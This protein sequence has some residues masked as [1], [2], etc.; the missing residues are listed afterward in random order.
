MPLVVV[1][2]VVVGLSGSVQLVGVGRVQ[3]RFVASLS[4]AQSVG[5]GRSLGGFSTSSMYLLAVLSSG[6]A[7]KPL[8]QISFCIDILW[9]AFEC[10]DW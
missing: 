3:S 5:V 10:P 7:T 9:L 8:P 4:G 1:V 6:T 2:F